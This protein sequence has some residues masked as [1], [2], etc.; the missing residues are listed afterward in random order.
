MDEI[1][2]GLFNIGGRSYLTN[3]AIQGVEEAGATALGTATGLAGDVVSGMAFQPY[4]VTSGTGQV[5][6]LEQGGRFA[7]LGVTLSPEQQ[8]IMNTLQ[9]VAQTNA[10]VAGEDTAARASG[11]AGMLGIDLGAPARS[12]QDIFELLNAVQDPARERERLE[13]ENRL[14][15]QGRSGVRTAMFGGTPEELAIAKARE[16]ARRGT[17]VDAF[18]LARQ[19][20]QRRYDQATGLFDL[21]LRERGLG[22]DLASGLLASSFLPM[23]DLRRTATL[24]ADLGSIDQQAR[25]EAARIAAGLTESG[26]ES[27]MRANEIAMQGRIARNNAIA[28]MLLGEATATGGTTGGLFSQLLDLF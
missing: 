2:S 10:L 28:N 9:N 7:G 4:T 16:E 5:D 22:G 1:L 6:A 15:A 3:E 27:S 8:Q 19:D 14:F 18:N 11:L 25:T 24:G 26:L 21:A 17:A 12:E 23:D 20:E 13:L